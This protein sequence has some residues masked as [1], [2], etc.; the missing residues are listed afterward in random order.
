MSGDLADRLEKLADER[1]AF[2]EEGRSVAG[3]WFEWPM[4]IRLTPTD[5]SDSISWHRR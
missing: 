4:P 3:T 5:T 2:V 1:A